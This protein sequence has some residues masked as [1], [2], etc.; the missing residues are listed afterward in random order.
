MEWLYSC[1]TCGDAIGEVSFHDL[2]G[3][4]ALVRLRGGCTCAQVAFERDIS[5]PYD[6]LIRNTIVTGDGA[7]LGGVRKTL[8]VISE[9]DDV[10]YNVPLDA[11]VIRLCDVWAALSL[12]R[13]KILAGAAWLLFTVAAAQA[14][15]VGV[16]LR[17]QTLRESYS[18]TH[19]RALALA[20][21]GAL[22]YEALRELRDTLAPAYKAAY[23]LERV[24]VHKD[25]VLSV[26]ALNAAMQAA[27]FDPKYADD[28]ERETAYQ[29]TLARLRGLPSNPA[30]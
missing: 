25:A 12:E 9:W 4:Q 7:R 10:Y 3:E 26:G 29:N 27:Y 14:L 20:E 15:H 2:R 16:E 13:A 23:Q 24:G 5:V 22:D 21:S 11:A 17:V 18:A 19:A 6:V 28:S 30:L 1:P 8:V